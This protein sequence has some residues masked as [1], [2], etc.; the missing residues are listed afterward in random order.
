MTNKHAKKSADPFLWAWRQAGGWAIGHV[1]GP[2][3][4]K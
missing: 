4:T 3:N 1:V 2:G